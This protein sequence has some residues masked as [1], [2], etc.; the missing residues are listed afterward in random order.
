MTN[1]LTLFCCGSDFKG[2][3][4]LSA[5]TAMETKYFFHWSLWRC[6]HGNLRQWQQQQQ[7]HQMGSMPNCDSNGNNSKIK[8]RCRCSVNEPLYI[9]VSQKCSKPLSL[10]NTISDQLTQRW[11]W[12]ESV[13]RNISLE[14]HLWPFMVF[15]ERVLM[16]TYPHD[17]DNE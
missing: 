9:P 12:L 13:I 17:I 15:I 7:H 2:S 4:T 5:A 14:S 11:T 3:F 6:S 10:R 16:I 8:C 1:T